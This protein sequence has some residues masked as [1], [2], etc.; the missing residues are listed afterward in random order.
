MPYPQKHPLRPLSQQEERAVSQLAKASS[1]RVDTVRRAK[2]VLAVHAGEPFT[3]AATLSG[4]KSADSVSQLVERFNQQGLA[5]LSIAAGRGRK[6]T[7]SSS[8]RQQVLERLGS[9]PNREQDQSATWSLRL[10]QRTL[11]RDL[12]PRIGASTKSRLCVRTQP[13]LVPDWHG[14][15]CAKQASSPSTIRKP[16]RNNV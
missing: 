1:E 3:V 13:H 16:R 11:R 7:Y 8:Q 14:G 4:F 2:A 12:L 9:T 15:A 6:P 5:A 10:L